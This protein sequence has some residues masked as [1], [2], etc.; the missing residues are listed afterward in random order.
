[1]AGRGGIFP[2]FSVSA[3]LSVSNWAPFFPNLISAPMPSF[4][5]L[6]SFVFFLLPCFPFA[7]PHPTWSLSICHGVNRAGVIKTSKGFLYSIDRISPLKPYFT[8]SDNQCQPK[9]L[10][11]HVYLITDYVLL[12]LLTDMHCAHM[13]RN[14]G[15]P[16]P[17]P[18]P[19]KDEKRLPSRGFTP[20]R[21]E[22]ETMKKT[23][24]ILSTFISFC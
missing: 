19:E 6:V 8:V 16:A 1:M 14:M 21:N 17:P 11:V 23:K 22:A 15:Q 4:F 20:R 24:K 3:A 13:R 18:P 2:V 5:V 10:M 7:L 9:Y 12:T